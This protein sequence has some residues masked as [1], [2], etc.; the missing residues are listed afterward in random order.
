MLPAPRLDYKSPQAMAGVGGLESTPGDLGSLW[1]LRGEGCIYP[2][3]VEAEPA[4]G[5]PHPAPRP[6][7]AQHQRLS[8]ITFLLLLHHSQ[9]QE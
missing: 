4:I 7:P 6:A 5:S 8:L 1:V 9:S 2:E 3:N